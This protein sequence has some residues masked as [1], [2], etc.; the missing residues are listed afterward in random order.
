V[1]RFWRA[2]VTANIITR[3]LNTQALLIFSHFRL[4]SPY[5]PTH[6]YKARAPRTE[7]RHSRQSSSEGTSSARAQPPPTTPSYTS[8]FSSIQSECLP[9][10][11]P[12][13]LC[14][15]SKGSALV[16]HELTTTFN[17]LDFTNSYVACFTLLGMLISCFLTLYLFS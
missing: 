12:W 1:K 11:N 6:M 5:P 15:S 2:Y 7:S 13:K 8:P 14:L 16:G 3:S 4:S 9:T 17:F 10:R